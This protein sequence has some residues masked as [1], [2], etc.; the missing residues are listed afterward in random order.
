METTDFAKHLSNYLSKYLPAERA[1]SRNTILS[2]RDTF[3]LFIGYMKT[4]KG[5]A[6]EKLYLANITKP[7]VVEFLNWLQEKRKSSNATRNYRMAAIH[8][9][10]SYLQYEMPEKIN[11]WQE[12]LSIKVKRIDRKS[13]SYLT[14][15]GVKLL[16][17]QI[18]TANR[19]GRRDLALLSLMYDT[20]A[21]VQE[22]IDLSP[23][24]LRLENPAIV[25]LFGKGRKERIV[26]LQGEQVKILTAYI[27]ENQ[28]DRTENN[29]SPLFSNNRGEKLTRSGITYI[30]NHYVENA[31]KYNPQLLPNRISPHTLRHS[32]AMHL[33]QAG[34]NLIY[35]RDLLG[36]VTI[37]T[38]EIYARADSKQK[39]EALEKAYADIIPKKICT[40][41]W[42]KNETLLFWLKNL[43]K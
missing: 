22:I 26:P 33:L 1:A 9:F 19:Q 10:F 13:I 29:T 40:G 38:T 16:L 5:I 32:K 24:A 7:V 17:E 35:I 43:D 27:T 41:S 2:Y 15:D 23:S 30:L 34:V 4:Q 3:I 37:K 31:R 14:L 6:A 11:Q 18:D 20:G 8:S 21:R 25:K 42:E 12:I 39:R 28:L 36:H